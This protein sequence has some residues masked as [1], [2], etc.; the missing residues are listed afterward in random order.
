MTSTCSI[1]MRDLD[2]IDKDNGICSLTPD[3][4][5]NYHKVFKLVKGKT[6]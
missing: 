4:C 3:N 6:Y 5:F 1:L 2:V